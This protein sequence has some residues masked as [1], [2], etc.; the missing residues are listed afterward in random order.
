LVRHLS[1]AL[2][3]LGFSMSI[4][5]TRRQTEG[6]AG[7]LLPFFLCSSSRGVDNDDEKEDPG[8]R[9]GSRV[10]FVYMSLLLLSPSL[11]QY[12]PIRHRMSPSEHEKPWLLWSLLSKVSLSDCGVSVALFF[13]L[14][15]LRACMA[16][17][18]ATL[19]Q[20]A[21]FGLC[22]GV[23]AKRVQSHGEVEDLPGTGRPIAPLSDQ[24]IY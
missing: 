18:Q 21:F 14:V 9:N 19:S 11:A 10:A 7:P 17:R 1:T 15:V 22:T 16:D 3:F 6:F 23:R 13:C 24:H 20:L 4:A 8:T 12:I 5:G 2:F